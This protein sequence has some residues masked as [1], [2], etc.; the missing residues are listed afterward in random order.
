MTN[1]A[2]APGPAPGRRT[3][4]TDIAR[5]AEVSVSTVSKVLNGHTDISAQTRPTSSGC[6]M[7]PDT[8]EPGPPAG[9]A[10]AT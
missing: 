1:D 5:R 2:S 3:T 9:T 8:S 6:S 10:G 4:I 7:T